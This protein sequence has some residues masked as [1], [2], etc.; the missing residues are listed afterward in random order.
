[1]RQK[2]EAAKPSADKVIKDIHR[3][4]R[5]EMIGIVLEGLP[6]EKRSRPFA[7]EKASR[8]SLYHNWPKEFLEAGKKRLAGDTARAATT[9]EG[10]VLRR[11]TDDLKEVVAE[12]ALETAAAQKSMIA[13]GGD[14]G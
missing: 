9:D 1:M 3:A 13:D 4:T 6:T 11:E 2:T 14:E 7:G 5:K 10:K 12:P 8:K